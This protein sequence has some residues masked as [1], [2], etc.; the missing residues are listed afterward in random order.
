ML[1]VQ[2]GQA[3][4]AGTQLLELAAHADASLGCCIEGLAALLGSHSAHRETLKSAVGLMLERFPG[5]TRLPI[6][7]AELVF[8]EINEVRHR[9]P[10]LMLCCDRPTH[11]QLLPQESAL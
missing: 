7:L 5:D 8:G 9:F 11:M 10:Q 6:W 2:L 3:D 4:S 1:A